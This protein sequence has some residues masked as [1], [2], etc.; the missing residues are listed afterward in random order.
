MDTIPHL[1]TQVP[2]E[3][4]RRPRGRRALLTL[5]LVLMLAGAA[6]LAARQV[7]GFLGDILPSLPSGGEGRPVEEGQ[8]VEY[9]VAPGAS[10]RS[11][12]RGLAERGVIASSLEFELAVRTS[13]VADQLQAGRYDLHTGM[14]VDTVLEVLLSGPDVETFWITVVEG[15]RIEEVLDSIAGQSDYSVEELTETLL[16]GRVESALLPEPA[17]ELR[18]WEGLLFPD[19]YEF[20]ADASPEGILARMASTLEERVESIEESRLE[21]LGLTRYQAMVVASLVEAE[22]KVDEDRGPVASVIYNRLE[23]GMALEID[24]TVLYA[25]GQRGGALTFA[26]LEVES[27][28][29]TY[30]SPGLPPTPIGAPGL[31]SLRAALDPPE[32]DYLYYVLTDPSG[33]HSFTDSYDEFLRLK[34]QAK[35]DGVIP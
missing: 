24:A 22:A 21:E 13:G 25:L 16:E 30:R 14:D 23:L 17:D 9:V 2:P 31:E 8:P 1:E 10:A 35:E 34:E 19:T 28:Y 12:G 6:V 3:P 11:I 27:P 20:V 29:N 33:T 15:L 5:V 7:L 4:P 18:D 32:T 26:D